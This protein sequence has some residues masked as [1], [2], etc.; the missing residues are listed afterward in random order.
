M[1]VDPDGSKGDRALQLYERGLT[2]SLIAERLGVRP[3]NVAGMLQRAK[4]RREVKNNDES[5]D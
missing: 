4:Q 2:K 5:F 1:R 3:S